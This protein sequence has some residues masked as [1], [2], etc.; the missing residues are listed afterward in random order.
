MMSQCQLR[1]YLRVWKWYTIKMRTPKAQ[2]ELIDK[3]EPFG[4]TLRPGICNVTEALALANAGIRACR[5]SSI[6]MILAAKSA[7][8]CDILFD[9]PYGDLLP[10]QT[11]PGLA[12]SLLT[13]SLEL[14]PETVPAESVWLKIQTDALSSGVPWQHDI[15]IADWI[16]S[17]PDT[18]SFKGIAADS[19][20]GGLALNLDDHNAAYVDMITTLIHVRERLLLSGIAACEL[21]VLDP[22]SAIHQHTF[23]GVAQLSPPYDIIVPDASAEG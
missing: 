11:E 2:R 8:I 14:L 21:M 22:Y 10:F 3:T 6:E 17:I 20:L 19:K 16:A 4:I 1:G 23:V 9:G 5:V 13:D 12:I 7:G 18:L 15:G